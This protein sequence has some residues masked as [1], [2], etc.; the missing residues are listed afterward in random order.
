MSLCRFAMGGFLYRKLFM[1]ARL[2]LITILSLEHA[3][4]PIANVLLAA[5]LFRFVVTVSIGFTGY[6]SKTTLSRN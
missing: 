3:Y 1:K 5:G 2:I 6:T 4:P